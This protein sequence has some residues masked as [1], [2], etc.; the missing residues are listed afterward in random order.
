MSKYTSKS[1]V[2]GIIFLGTLLPILLW[3]CA[4]LG[5]SEA[6]APT[7]T[8]AAE[9]MEVAAAPAQPVDPRLTKFDAAAITKIRDE[10]L[11]RS[12]VAQT[13]SYLTDVIGPRLTGSPNLLRANKWTRDKLISWGLQ[14]AAMEAWGPFGRGW[15]LKRFSAEVVEPQSIPLIA[16]P[17]A[18]SPGLEQPITAE[19]V[20]MEPRTAEELDA[21]A[22]KLEGK[23]VLM[24]AERAVTARFTPQGT[25]WT[26]EQLMAMAQGRGNRGGNPFARG[27]RGPA[28]APT[29][30]PGGELLVAGP[31][32]APTTSR[33]QLQNNPAAANALTTRMLN[34][35][36][37]EK[38]ALICTASTNGDGGT[39]FIQSAT[40]ATP[41]ESATQPAT[42]PGRGRANRGGGGRGASQ[43]WSTTPPPIPP[44]ITI[45]VEHYNRLARMIKAG[46]K[47]TM[48]VNLQVEY[49]TEDTM[50]YNTVAEIPGT[51][52]KDEIVML[53]GHLD[54]WHS[55]TG[56]TD[57]G[58]GVAAAMEAVRIIQASGLKPRRTIRIALWTGEE[59]GLFGSQQYV[60]KH[61]GTVQGGRG[62]GAG[63]GG[64]AARGAG[65]GGRGA[66][67]TTTPIAKGPEYDRLSVYF[68]LDNG[69]GKI[70]GIFAQSNPAVI[71]IFKAWLAP[72]ADLG[73]TTVTPNNTGSTDHVPFD[74]IGL[75]GFQ[76]IQ[77]EIEYMARTHHSNADVFDRIQ[78][79]DLKQASTIMAAFVYNAAMMDEKIPRKPNFSAAPANAPTTTPA[80]DEVA[81]G[82]Q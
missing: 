68:N 10:G 64:G 43:V 50:A 56:A 16:F 41:A 77:D 22:G 71:P 36:F 3:G 26:D 4:N 51:D 5:D 75:P 32:S 14:N 33:G 6:T 13:L 55:G 2:T 58:A 82:A 44:Q 38:A 20:L 61:F 35:A 78:T 28:T 46:E 42:Q 52:L 1:R 37:R 7:T 25:R 15:S 69:T 66:G 19:V 39:M 24:G 34:L 8:P 60:G 40:A 81:Q 79:D 30:A 57:N 54:S 18:W 12:Q 47:V 70:R 17:K 62:R 67:P 72:F 74:N 76:F 59:E 73:A 29:S 27:G 65:R 31:A 48:A 53:G 80:E 11:N 49:Q 45:A 9:Q 63:G 23:I 21:F